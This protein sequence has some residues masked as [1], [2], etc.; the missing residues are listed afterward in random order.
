M[1]Q[2]ARKKPAP[3]K[4]HKP[5]SYWPQGEI[6][7]TGHAITETTEHGKF[8]PWGSTMQLE[9]EI[10]DGKGGFEFGS[11]THLRIGQGYDKDVEPVGWEA[12]VQVSGRTSH[13]TQLGRARAK[14]LIRACDLADM[15][16][17]ALKGAADPWRDNPA[18]VLR[19]FGAT[20][21]F[22]TRTSHSN[23][24]KGDR[25]AEVVVVLNEERGGK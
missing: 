23:D 10:A 16:V 8:N 2:G 11:G 6:V 5:K 18:A 17:V 22:D 12:S 24:P 13:G 3:V 21:G 9:I 20:L 15:F 14:A 4:S 19:D 7:V 25:N 1:T